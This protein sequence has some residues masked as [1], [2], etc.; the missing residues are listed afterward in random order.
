MPI[1]A[2]D[3]EFIQEWRHKK[4]RELVIQRAEKRRR[5]TEKPRDP[6]PVQLDRDLDRAIERDK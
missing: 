2:R 1:Y 6:K 3:E 5:Q 4:R